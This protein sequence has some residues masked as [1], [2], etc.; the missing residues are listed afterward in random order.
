MADRN[1]PAR[2]ANRQQTC[3]PS[4]RLDPPVRTLR[5]PP[6]SALIE[7]DGSRPSGRSPQR[8]RS[9]CGFHR[10]QADPLGGAPI[11]VS[12]EHTKPGSPLDE[13][14]RRAQTQALL[15]L[16]ADYVARQQKGP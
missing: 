4:A 11:V 10:A 13:H 12:I 3:A 7:D 6:G 16:L 14:L 15:D 9:R 2:K 5:S 8:R 1:T